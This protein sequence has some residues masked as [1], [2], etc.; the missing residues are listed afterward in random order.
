MLLNSYSNEIRLV[1]VRSIREVTRTFFMGHPVFRLAGY[2]PAPWPLDPLSWPL[3]YFSW[4]L[5]PFSWPLD[6]FSWP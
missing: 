4:P 3:D 6:P 5:N 1:I 2:A